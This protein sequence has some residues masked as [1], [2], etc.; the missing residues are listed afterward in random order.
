MN[1]YIAL[2]L[3]I[4]HLALFFLW[5]MYSENKQNLKECTLKGVENAKYIKQLN[6]T[7]IETTKKIKKLREVAGK[8]NCNNDRSCD[9]YN[10]PIDYAILNELYK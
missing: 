2:Y 3:L 10:M 6:A 4:I 5:S 8:N 9:C 1:K 7:A